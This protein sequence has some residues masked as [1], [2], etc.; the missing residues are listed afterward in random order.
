MCRV[1][2]CHRVGVMDKLM[3]EL[4]QD[5][6]DVGL[7]DEWPVGG[8]RPLRV[9][10]QLLAIGRAEHGLFAVNGVC[11]HAGGLLGKGSIQGS[12]LV[13]PRHGFEFSVKTGICVDD[14][15]LSVGVCPIREYQAH[16]QVRVPSRT[17]P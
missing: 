15:S 7:A 11:P 4:G 6:Y 16:V 12:Y 9:A 1:R 10:A 8:V 2:L 17:S 5:W 13:C 14:P 3:D